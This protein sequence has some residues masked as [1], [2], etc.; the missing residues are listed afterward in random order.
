MCL[1]FFLVIEDT[2]EFLSKVDKNICTMLPKAMNDSLDKLSGK[3]K[4]EIVNKIRKFY[5]NDKPVSKQTYGH[6]IDVCIIN[7]CHGLLLNTYI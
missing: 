5:F 3:K 1:C 7:F 4:Q 2:D 6:L